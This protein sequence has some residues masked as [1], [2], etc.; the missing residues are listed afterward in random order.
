M[1]L[2]RQTELQTADAGE[3]SHSQR[4]AQRVVDWFNAQP[5]T[6]IACSGGIDS[7]LL[8]HVAASRPGVRVRVVHAVS[9]AVPPDA[10][11]RVVEQATRHGWVLEQVETGEFA[12]ERYLANP[13]DRC[14]HCKSHLY[15]VLDRIAQRAAVDG[16]VVVSGANVDDLGEYRPGLKAA[17]AYGVRHTY[18]E[19]GIGKVGIRGIARALDLPYAELPASPCLASRLYTGTRVT[20]A[21]LRFVNQ[22]EQIVRRLTGCAVVRCR[23]EADSMRVEVPDADRARVDD[24]VLAALREAARASLPELRWVSLDALAYAPGRAFVGTH[25]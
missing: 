7:L 2:V 12:D 8:A 5:F 6:A 19:L 20:P 13:V 14:F 3:A 16:G 17:A 25:S 23:I 15:A 11:A 1:T 10:T 9:A 18:V 24:T 21:R 4:D 22:A